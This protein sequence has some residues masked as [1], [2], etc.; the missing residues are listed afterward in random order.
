[1]TGALVLPVS[2]LLLAGLHACLTRPLRPGVLLLIV[3]GFILAPLAAALEV[4]RIS[5]QR[6]LVLLPFAALLAG[7]G[8]ERLLSHRAGRYIAVLV[9]ML[10]AL[11]VFTFYALY[12]PW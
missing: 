4:S 5:I 9:A 3:L 1:M 8:V 2:V 12:L 6:A 7:A 10:S 11:Q